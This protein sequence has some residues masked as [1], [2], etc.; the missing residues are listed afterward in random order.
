MIRAERGAALLSPWNALPEDF[1]L[2]DYLERYKAALEACPVAYAGRWAQAC[3]PLGH[4]GAAYREVRLDLGCGKG[5]FTVGCALCEP[6]VLFI[7]MDTDPVCV[8]FAACLAC[9]NDARNAVFVPGRDGIL[10]QVFAPGELAVIYLNF[11][12][13]HPKGR[14]AAMRLTHAGRLAVYRELLAEDGLLCLQTDNQPFFS[15]T[16]GQLQLAGYEVLCASEDARAEFPGTPETAYERRAVAMGAKI[17]AIHAIP[18]VSP[19]SADADA[20]QAAAV[21]PAS[22]YDYLP[23]GL[24]TLAYVPPEMARAVAAIRRTRAQALREK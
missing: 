19:G 18:R 5:A 22:L 1:V 2:E 13:P 11:P 15:Y 10:A 7:G 9:E 16:L 21:L 12:T 20:H 6:D 3:C 14:E 23:S 24:D 4:G 17:C 8:A